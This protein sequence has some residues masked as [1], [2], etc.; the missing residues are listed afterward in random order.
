MGEGVS[1]RM[2]ERGICVGALWEMGGTER[3]VGK[4]YSRLY[5]NID[6]TFLRVHPLR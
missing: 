2:S 5:K 3:V 6:Y 1:Q 4:K